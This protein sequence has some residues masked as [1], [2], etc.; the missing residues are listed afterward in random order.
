MKCDKQ[1]LF[2]ATSDGEQKETI[3]YTEFAKRIQTLNCVH[4]IRQ[5]S[6]CRAQEQ[7]RQ[8]QFAGRMKSSSEEH[9]HRIRVTA[10]ATEGENIQNQLSLTAQS[11]LNDKRHCARQEMIIQ[12][13]KV[14]CGSMQEA[15]HHCNCR[16]VFISLK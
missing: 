10:E 12:K 9:I 8:H 11:E 7:K 3:K 14:E 6:E 13:R 1:R 2:T 4:Q 5:L 16:N 15:I